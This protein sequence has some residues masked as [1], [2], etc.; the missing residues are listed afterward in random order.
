VPLAEGDTGRPEEDRQTLAKE[1]AGRAVALLQ[2]AVA[3]GFADP[4]R[5]ANDPAF[6]AVRS[7]ADFE[8]V[9]AELRARKQ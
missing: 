1:Y 2:R 9:I 3:Q 7:R 5:L 8:Q 4:D 6:A